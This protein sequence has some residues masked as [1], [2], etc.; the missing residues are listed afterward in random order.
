MQISK[1]SLTSDLELDGDD[2]NLNTPYIPA[3]SFVNISFRIFNRQINENNGEDR[4]FL[5]ICLFPE[6]MIM[7][8]Q[9]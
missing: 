2:A 1:T 4:I 9:W 3:S 5:D 6:G 7:K 8:L